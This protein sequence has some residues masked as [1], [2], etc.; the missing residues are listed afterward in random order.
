M[1]YKYFLLIKANTSFVWQTEWNWSWFTD[2][3][4]REQTIEASHIPLR[5]IDQSIII[6]I[7]RIKL[8]I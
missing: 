8:F 5:M 2:E 3:L 7:L 1:H 4:S 6:N